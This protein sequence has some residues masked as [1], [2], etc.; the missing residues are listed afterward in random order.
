MLTVHIYELRE[1]E[2]D[3]VTG[4]GS[5]RIARNYSAAGASSSIDSNITASS[6]T[7]RIGNQTIQSVS[8][9]ETSII[10]ST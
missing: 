7:V 6:T 1:E 10:E 4:G 9:E 5:V 2:L 8:L 3:A